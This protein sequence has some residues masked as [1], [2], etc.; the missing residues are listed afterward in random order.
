MLSIIIPIYNEGKLAAS[1]L[2]PI[3]ELPIDKEI[4]VV[5]D[6]STDDT[7]TVLHNLSLKY[8]FRLITQAVNQG[9]GAAVKRGLVEARG[10]YLIVCDA[11]NEYDPQ[12]IPRL[13]TET[14]KNKDSKVAIF[15]SR[16]LN[17]NNSGWHYQINHFLTALTNF[18]F[19]SQLTDMETC[20]KLIPSGALN[21]L[22]LSGRR[23]EIEPEMT[24]QL[25]KAGYHIKEVSISYCRRGYGEGKKIKPRDGL[26]AILT[27]LK[28]RFKI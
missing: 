12:D 26:L 27:L 11:D 4:I 7:A 28:E 9:K 1:A 5:N 22:H 16:W 10:S 17:K 20:F 23:F 13:L 24:V 2:P 8:N 25:I 18:L 3:F 15:G 6:G 14:S 19:G 21:D